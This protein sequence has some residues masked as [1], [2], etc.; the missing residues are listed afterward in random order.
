MKT[1]IM[2]IRTPPPRSGGIRFEDD[3]CRAECSGDGELRCGC[4]SLMARLVAGQVELRCR[5]CKRL[6]TIPIEAGAR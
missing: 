5:R 2:F 4:G 1:I 6:W 3:P